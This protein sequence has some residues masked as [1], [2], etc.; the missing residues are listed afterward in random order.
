V[1]FVF[2]VGDHG[3]ELIEPE[4]LAVLADALLLEEDGSGAVELDAQGDIQPAASAL[5]LGFIGGS[6]ALK[7]FG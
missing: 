4:L 6:G 5:A 3:A 2:G 7:T 1:A